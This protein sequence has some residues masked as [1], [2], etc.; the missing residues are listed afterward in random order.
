MTH[1]FGPWSRD[2]VWD[3]DC[4]YS[5][6]VGIRLTT[7]LRLIDFRSAISLPR[8]LGTIV[9]SVAFIIAFICTATRAAEG[10]LSW[11]MPLQEPPRSRRNRDSTAFL[12]IPHVLIVHRING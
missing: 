2:R 11:P 9:A 12:L 4:R 3:W 10:I 6:I 5:V 7:D 8:L 1:T